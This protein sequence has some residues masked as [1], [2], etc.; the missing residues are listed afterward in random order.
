[1][2]HEPA[3]S[4]GNDYASGYKTKAGLILFFVYGF[5]YFGFIILNTLAPRMMEV[6][7]VL[8]LNLAVTYGFGL[9]LLAIGMGLIYNRL[10]TRKEK[11]MED[12]TG[13]N[14]G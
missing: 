8:G 2:F 3:A 6:K 14:A 7:I 13:G 1:M 12:G 4:S 11:E 5:I 9:I 10:C